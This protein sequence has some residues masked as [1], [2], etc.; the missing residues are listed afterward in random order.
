MYLNGKENVLIIE[1]VMEDEKLECLKKIMK[2]L[3]DLNEE[4]II[5]YKDKE[6]TLEEFNFLALNNKI[7]IIFQSNNNISLGNFINNSLRRRPAYFILL[8]EDK[9]EEL[10]CDKIEEASCVGWNII[11]ITMKSNQIYKD[12]KVNKINYLDGFV[13]KVNK[14]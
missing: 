8:I 11:I 1:N 9:D 10:F 2:E 14:F 4:N 5:I 12:A 13:N 3:E 7:K 6:P